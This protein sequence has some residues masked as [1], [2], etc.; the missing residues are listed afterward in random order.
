M[1]AANAISTI[2]RL[3]S[4]SIRAEQEGNDEPMPLSARAQAGLLDALELIAHSMEFEADF[5]DAHDQWLNDDSSE[6]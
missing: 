6:K 2:A 5:V 4:N 3:V 1:R